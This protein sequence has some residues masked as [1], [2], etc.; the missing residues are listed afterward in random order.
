MQW[1]DVTRKIWGGPGKILGEEWHPPSSDPACHVATVAPLLCQQTQKKAFVQ[2][3]FPSN[4]KK[5]SRYF[6]GV[7]LK[8]AKEPASVTSTMPWGSA[9][10]TLF[11]YGTL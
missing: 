10:Q 2:G 1:H 11:R 9:F 3:K 7:N 6:P 8:K 5:F 4:E